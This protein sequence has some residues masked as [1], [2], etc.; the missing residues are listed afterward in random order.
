[1]PETKKKKGKNTGSRSAKSGKTAGKKKTAASRDNAFLPQIAPLILVACAVLIAVCV[2][3]DQGVIS[4]GIR[5]V[6]TGLLGGAVYALPMLLLV[7]AL[8]LNRDIGEGRS[9]SRSVSAAAVLV[10]LAMTLHILGKGSPVT[11]AKIHYAEG[12]TLTGGGVLGGVLG[13]LLIRGFGPV[14]SLIVLFSLLLFLCLYIVGIS[15]RGV[16]AALAYHASRLADTIRE[17]REA[18]AQIRQTSGPTRSQLREEEHLRYLREKRARKQE[19]REAE[20]LSPDP[21]TNRK[22]QGAPVSPEQIP[23]ADPMQA[24]PIL[25]EGPVPENTGRGQPRKARGRMKELDIPVSGPAD[26]VGMSDDPVVL[27]PGR[28]EEPVEKDPDTGWAADAFRAPEDLTDPVEAELASSD[29]DS[30]AVDEKI[31]DEV[32]RRTRER[33]GRMTNGADPEEEE[34]LP[35]PRA[36][37]QT[38]VSGGEPI[39]DDHMADYTADPESG[40]DTGKRKPGSRRNARPDQT[41]AA[42]AFNA[43]QFLSDNIPA[44]D[45]SMEDAEPEDPFRTETEDLSFTFGETAEETGKQSGGAVQEE[46]NR[47][48]EFDDGIEAAVNAAASQASRQTERRTSGDADRREKKEGG[49][50]PAEASRRGTGESGQRPKRTGEAGTDTAALVSEV[51]GEDDISD[52][53]LNPED[54]ELL[55]RLSEQYRNPLEVKRETVSEPPREQLRESEA[56]AYLFPPTELLTEDPGGGNEDIKDELQ[57]NAVKLVDTLKSFKVN[58]KIE[59]ISRGPTI[60]RYEL[61]PEPGTKVRSITN[62]VDDIALNLATTGVRIEAPIPGKSAVGIEVPNKKRTTVHLRTLLEDERFV[63]AKSRLTVALGEDVAG[64]PVFFDVGKMPHLLIAGTTGSG[65]SVCI[66]TIIMSLLYKASPDD[67]KMILIDPKKVE[68]NIY[69]GIPHLL[70]PVVS[71]PKKAAGSLSWAVS[72]MERRYGLIEDAGKRNI[73]EYNKLADANPDYEHLPSIVIII[74]ELADLMMTAPDDV[75]DSICRI[76]QKARAAGMYLI[77]G[78]QR[79]SVDVITGLIKANIPS[80]I[81]FRTSNQVDSRTIIDIGSAANLIGMGDMLFAPVG[82]L[83]PNRVQ[84][85]FVSE[86]DVMEAVRYIRSMNQ[87]DES[88]S[89]EI[90]NQIEREAQRCGAGKKGAAQAQDDE[91]DTGDE[92]PMLK[93]AIEVALDAGKIS[94]SLIQRKLKLGYGRAAKLIDRMEQLGYVS[95]PNGPHPREVLITRSQWQEIGMRD[96]DPPPFDL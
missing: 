48:N 40:A 96:D 27:R 12:K 35:G 52:L 80:R 10:F 70:V 33:S 79:P 95:A 45:D 65:K 13:Q 17:K 5:G 63:S 76:A 92:D 73:G 85:A 64:D 46:E 94:T 57:E 43:D 15:P 72:E 6:L 21:V 49:T 68:L 26:S 32:M 20:A 44:D 61:V 23:L 29:A 4:H 28:R 86:D 22:K 30:A 51:A 24:V 16:W 91:E 18:E 1:M 19:A 66:N 39:P 83:K 62:L 78:T 89:D 41:F 25:Q 47:E 11:E 31:F 8:L 58:T 75:E 2:I 53:F 7:R 54:A 84:G 60:T 87:T 56:P 37:V 14:I 77:V 71:E 38:V 42:D 67:V 74:D 93:P 82:A 59:N 9:I 34:S 50:H 90:V 88:Y 55:D 36:R 81:A 3:L 69:N